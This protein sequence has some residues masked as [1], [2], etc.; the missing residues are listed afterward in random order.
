M[1]YAKGFNNSN[2][3]PYNPYGY[4]NRPRPVMGMTCIHGMPYMNNPYM[5]SMP[6]MPPMTPGMPGMPTPGM[7]EMP[8]PGMP[9]MPYTSPNIPGMPPMDL[10]GMPFIPDSQMPDM[11]ELPFDFLP[12]GDMPALPAMP[13][14][15]MNGMPMNCQQ[16][17]ELARAMGC[18]D[19]MN[20]AKPQATDET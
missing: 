6:G 7:P 16:L 19:N 18:L 12:D 9:G 2:M 5:Q 10:P 20:E 13:E 15:P 4:E 3:Y 8:T 11:P 1:N 14:M 17:M